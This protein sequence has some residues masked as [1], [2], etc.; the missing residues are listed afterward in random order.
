MS[1]VQRALSET[2]ASASVTA[3]RQCAPAERLMLRAAAEI[4]YDPLV[5]CEK[6]LIALLLSA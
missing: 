4:R 3:I 1:E 6:G 2:A 5:Y